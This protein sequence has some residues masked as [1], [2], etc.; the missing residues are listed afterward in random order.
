MTRQVKDM[1][2]EQYKEQNEKRLARG[3]EHNKAYRLKYPEKYEILKNEYMKQYYKD[4]KEKMNKSVVERRRNKR[5]EEK[6]KLI[7]L[8]FV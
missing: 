1:T 5:E 7:N 3:R 4:N 2:L 6:Q 8:N